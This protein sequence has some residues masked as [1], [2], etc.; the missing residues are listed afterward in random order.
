MAPPTELLPPGLAFAAADVRDAGA[1]RRLFS[2]ALAVFHLASHGMSGG[3]QLQRSLVEAIN[4]GGTRTVLAACA[5][6]GVQRCVYLSTYNVVFGGQCIEGGDETL[7]YFP[8]HRHPDAYSRTK[9]EAE[10]AALAADGTP[11]ARQAQLLRTCALRPAGIYGPG[12]R[13]H[14]PRM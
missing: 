1:L 9:A 13:R 10:M 2:G 5:A 3:A 8:P 14:L 7:P 4:V 11:L 6:A 12:E